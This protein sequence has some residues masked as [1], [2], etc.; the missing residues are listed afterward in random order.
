MNGSILLRGI[1]FGSRLQQHGDQCELL[2]P[3]DKTESP[4]TGK[5]AYVR[6]SMGERYFQRRVVAIGHDMGICPVPEGALGTLRI[7]G[8]YRRGE[9]ECCWPGLHRFWSAVCKDIDPLKRGGRQAFRIAFF[10]RVRL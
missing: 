6:T 3:T 8:T 10:F 7:T 4:A 9:C 1:R 2:L 5:A